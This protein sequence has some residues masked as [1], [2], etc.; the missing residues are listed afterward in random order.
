M[1]KRNVEDIYQLAPSQQGI[2]YHGL[3]EP[4]SGVYLIH[5]SYD[6][7]GTLEQGSF[8]QAWRRVAARHQPLRTSFHWRDVDTPVQVVHS[9]VELPT[10]TY[11]WRDIPEAELAASLAT[12][13]AEQQRP[14]DFEKA[15][16]MRL[17]LARLSDDRYRF[18]WT[19]H[20]I[21]MEGWS[22]SFVLQEVIECY[23]AA[24]E[25]MEVELSPRKPFRDYVVWLQAQNPAQAE[26]YWRN[27][28][29]G[30]TAQTRLLPREAGTRVLESEGKPNY[31]VSSTSLSEDATARLESLARH[32]GL[33]LNTPSTPSW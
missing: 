1:I 18:C 4:A 2:L 25:N 17:A 7:E 10:D 16:L 14:F 27:T 20:H 8:W 9:D 29:R 21:L 32:H 12:L 33:T 19:F 28:L 11:D 5:L 15:P 23:R 22:M 24:V 26:Q 13:E 30:F 6:L 31:L 3:S